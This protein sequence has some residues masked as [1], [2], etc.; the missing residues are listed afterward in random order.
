MGCSKG[1][2]FDAD[3]DIP[4]LSG[5]VIVVTGGNNGL[6]KETSLQL[7]KHNPAKIFMGARSEEKAATAIRKI[8]ESVPDA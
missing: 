5:K 7:A 6:G 2:R 1:V 3:I 8:K 4:D